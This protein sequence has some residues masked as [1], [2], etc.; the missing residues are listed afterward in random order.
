MLF[1][2]GNAWA[3]DAEAEGA[4]HAEGGEGGGAEATSAHEGQA[5]EHGEAESGPDWGLIGLQTVNF[6]LFAAIVFY[7]ARKPIGDALANRAAGVRRDL[8]ESAT[9]R[10][11]AERRYSEIERKLAGLSQRIEDLK[12]DAAQEAEMEAKRIS[13]RAEVDAA[14]IRDTAVRT[15]REE[16]LRAR[17]EIRRE[18]V[19]QAT[20]LAREIVRQGVT[21]ED[22]ARLQGEFLG[23]LTAPNSA[24]RPNGGEA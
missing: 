6:V 19:E 10:G 12:L 1:L 22:Q 18:V 17:G 9:L 2:S 21:P 5:A 11:D 7:F 16:V 13:E 15:M 3:G 14:R 20:A 24:A 8:D 23:S 4:A